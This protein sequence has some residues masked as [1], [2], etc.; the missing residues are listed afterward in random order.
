MYH[1]FCV[2]P[3]YL[4]LSPLHQ[5]DILNPEPNVLFNMIWKHV[6]QERE[7]TYFF[8]GTFL[9]TANVNEQIPLRDILEIHLNTRR[10]AQTKH[11][12][13]YLQVFVHPGINERLF[14]IDQLN[15]EMKAS[16]GYKEEDNY[17]T[18]LFDWEY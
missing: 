2:T 8:T 3:E 14:F 17:C 18:L 15:E 1:K 4:V 5:I 16:G 7:G 11:G 10:L 12:L 13:D 9:V 6:P